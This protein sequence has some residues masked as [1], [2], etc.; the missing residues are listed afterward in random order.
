MCKKIGIVLSLV[1]IFAFGSSMTV[2]AS[3]MNTNIVIPDPFESETIDDLNNAPGPSEMPGVS[4]GYGEYGGFGGFGVASPEKI[5][6]GVERV[7]LKPHVH[8]YEW[9]VIFSPSENKD[10]LAQNICACEKVDGEQPISQSFCFVNS[11]VEKIEKAPAGGIVIINPGTFRCYTAKM[12]SVLVEHPDITLKTVYTGSD[13]V[14]KSFSITAE[15]MK[16]E[17]A[18][19]YGFEYL[20]S[21][22]GWDE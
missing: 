21:T 5:P 18:L 17:N 16:E 22:Y 20:G 12:I 6:D 1:M 3:S 19:F 2:M 7:E 4:S 10:G 13:G 8:E 15:D 11:V 14:E 9:K